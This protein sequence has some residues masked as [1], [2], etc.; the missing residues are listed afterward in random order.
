MYFPCFIFCPVPHPTPFSVVNRQY[1][2]KTQGSKGQIFSIMLST[3]VF[4]FVQV[5]YEDLSDISQLNDRMRASTL[6]K[7]SPLITRL[8]HYHK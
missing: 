1:Y 8:I 3:T 4:R 5:I 6:P 2:Q 7:N